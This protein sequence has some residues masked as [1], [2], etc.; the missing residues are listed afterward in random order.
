MVHKM[1]AQLLSSAGSASILKSCLKIKK[2]AS[3]QGKRGEKN[4]CGSAKAQMPPTQKRAVIF[5]KSA[6][7]EPE[8]MS[9]MQKHPE[10]G[11][12]CG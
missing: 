4:A 3:V 10:N 5:N 2:S 12:T 1:D 9:T 7:G 11:Q 8:W 6:S